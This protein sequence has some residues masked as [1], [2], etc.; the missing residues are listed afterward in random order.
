MAY[1]YLWEVIILAGGE[2][3]LNHSGVEGDSAV[4][5]RHDIQG[6]RK[7]VANVVITGNDTATATRENTSMRERG[8]GHWGY[9]RGSQ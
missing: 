8:G 2:A 9:L 5:G 6:A 3:R 1:S 7:D 4:C